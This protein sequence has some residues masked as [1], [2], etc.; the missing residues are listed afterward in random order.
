M[1]GGAT[2]DERSGGLRLLFVSIVNHRQ[3]GI[4]RRKD[5]EILLIF[6]FND[7]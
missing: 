4:L 1:D 2:S 5:I 6:P 3:E 7:S